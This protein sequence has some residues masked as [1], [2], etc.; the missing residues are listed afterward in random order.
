MRRFHSRY[1]GS[2]CARHDQREGVQAGPLAQA[3]PLVALGEGRVHAAVVSWGAAC[4]RRRGRRARR[5][6]RGGRRSGRS[7]PAR[8]APPARSPR[9]PRGPR[10]SSGPGSRRASGRS[11]SHR[12]WGNGGSRS[13]SPAGR[14]RADLGSDCGSVVPRPAIARPGPSADVGLTSARTPRPARAGRAERRRPRA[15]A[16]PA[17]SSR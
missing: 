1:G 4:P 2:G 14:P 11:A 8:R 16:R 13:G 15:P 10:T 12:A 5:C 6:R 17:A 3:V 9:P 7:R